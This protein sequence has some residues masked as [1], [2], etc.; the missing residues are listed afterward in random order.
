MGLKTGELDFIRA[1]HTAHDEA[2]S[3]NR[4]LWFGGI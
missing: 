3:A 1:L 2:P 4:K